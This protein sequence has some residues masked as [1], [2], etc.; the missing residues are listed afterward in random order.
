MLNREKIVLSFIRNAKKPVSRFQLM[1]GLQG[2]ARCAP[3]VPHT[4]TLLHRE[5]RPVS[6]KLPPRSSG[7]IQRAYDQ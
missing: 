3:S 1:K 7:K 4:W 5:Y 2:S 6:K